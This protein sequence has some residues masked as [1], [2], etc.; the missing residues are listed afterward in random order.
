VIGFFFGKV[1][2]GWTSL[3]LIMVFF[4]VGQFGCL[5]IIGAYLGR[6]YMEVKQRP[7]FL[8]DEIVS[9]PC[10]ATAEANTR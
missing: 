9:S 10:D 2:P 5:A 8:I 4:G 3:A 6:T 1:E 7:L